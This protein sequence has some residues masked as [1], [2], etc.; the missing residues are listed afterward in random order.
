M[1]RVGVALA[2]LTCSAGVAPALASEHLPLTGSKRAE[3]ESVRTRAEGRLAVLK[4]ELE[5]STAV[6]TMTTM[7]KEETMAERREGHPHQTML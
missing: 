3:I 5:P 4:L 2:L 6:V 7:K 1:R